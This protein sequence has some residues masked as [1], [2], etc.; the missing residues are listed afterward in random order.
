M[1]ASAG[2]KSLNSDLT[3]TKEGKAAISKDEGFRKYPYNDQA[4]HCTVGTGILLHKGQCTPE[5]MSKEY[6]PDELSKTF[7]KRLQEAERYVRHYV[8]DTALTQDQFDSLTSFV[9]NVGVGNAKEALSLANDGE[10]ED[11]ATEMNKYVNVR[12]KDKSGKK[13]LQK[14][15]GLIIRRERESKPFKQG[16]TLIP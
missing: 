7:H 16:E 11:V 4:K 14:S 9:Y 1:P 10:H 2:K 8:K 6:D 12:V 15:S 5:E 3:V 13:H